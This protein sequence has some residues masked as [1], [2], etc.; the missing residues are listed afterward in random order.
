[1]PRHRH[2]AE[3]LRHHCQKRFLWNCS[4]NQISLVFRYF[5]DYQKNNYIFTPMFQERGIVVVAEAC[6]LPDMSRGKG[7]LV[8][9]YRVAM[10][11][12][13]M[14]GAGVSEANGVLH[15]HYYLPD[16]I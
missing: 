15:N 13:I 6:L 14:G 8:A 7:S 2:E 4:I 1:M 5:F 11:Q 10:T 9:S 3:T 16:V 12:I